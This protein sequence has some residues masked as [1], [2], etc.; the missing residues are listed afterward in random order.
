VATLDVPTL[1]S[2][3]EAAQLRLAEVADI[4]HRTDRLHVASVG[5]ASF[6]VDEDARSDA[7]A[8]YDDLVSAIAEGERRRRGEE[9][10][11]Q[12]FGN[13]IEGLRE[14]LRRRGRED[15]L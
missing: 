7:A 14:E 13:L 3:V 10:S 4:L 5:P 9:A 6:R 2:V 12:D 11:G 15:L 1:A 8:A